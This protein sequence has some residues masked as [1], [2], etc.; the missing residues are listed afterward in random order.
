M[1]G[2]STLL[3]TN[4]VSELLRPRPDFK[5]VAFVEGQSDLRVSAIVFHELSLGLSLMP[6]GRKKATL[7]AGIESFRLAFEGRVV[8]VDLSVAAIAGKLRA[9]EI[10]AGFEG[11]GID[12]LIG[13]CAIVS[14]ARLATRNTKDFLRMGV[15][16]VNPWTA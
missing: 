3:D 11:D 13:A 5:V 9:G 12:A 14:S 7:S 6:E 8:A 15:E 2:R 1:T 10:Q 4:V 16:L